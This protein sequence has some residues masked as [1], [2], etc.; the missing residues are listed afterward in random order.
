MC[1]GEEGIPEFEFD[2]DAT[3]LTIE[4]QIGKGGFGTVYLGLYLGIRVAI[5][6]I[7]EGQSPEERLFIKREVAILKGI[8]HPNCVQLVGLSTDKEG[9]LSIV[10]DF[11]S[12]GNLR[13]VVKDTAR[14]LDW[15]W[16]MSIAR[17]VAGAM[18]YLHKKTFSFE[19]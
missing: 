6:K 13:S 18:A 10:M 4:K 12:G 19:I 15:S 9:H 2:I 1:S 14:H 7:E 11:V 17:D 16:R 5:K 3:D 8:R